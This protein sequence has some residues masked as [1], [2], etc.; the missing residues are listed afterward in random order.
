MRAPLTA[1]LAPAAATALLCALPTAHAGA[2]GIDE[3]I[4]VAVAGYPSIASVQSERQAAASRIAQAWAR[5]LPVLDVGATAR[6]RGL[7]P[8]GP[9]P[10]L[11]VNVYAGGSIEALVDRETL[12]ERSL[13][14]REAQVREEVAF[15]A[16]QAYLRLLRSLRV[17]DARR[18]SVQRHQRLVADFE[19]I[20]RMDP[21]RRYDLVQARSRL[22]V[23]EGQLQDAVAEV[24]SARNVLAK[25]Y[26]Y[27]WDE[28]AMAL[29]DP[30]RGA[31]D[32]EPDAT[33][34]AHP[35]V[36][37]ARHALASAQAN[38]RALRLERGPRLDFEAQGGREALSRFVL[39]WP[40]LDRT[41]GAAEQGA[42]AAL[43]GAEAAVRQA[44]LEVAEALAQARED[45]AAALRRLA[46]ANAQ[47]ALDR[48]LVD[49]Y[50][51]QFRIGRRNLLDLLA[52]FA[53]LGA[54]EARLAAGEV[55]VALAGVRHAFAAG[56]LADAYAATP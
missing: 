35:A 51:A 28:A 9:L 49:I 2:T 30:T 56:R 55:D 20:T 13:E 44:E 39:S 11:R 14:R 19:Q 33:L 50:F 45:Q 24:A 5:H 8:S 18:A 10:R 34:A 12:L 52:A 21:G 4:R 22:S 1:R 25:Y 17:A 47:A 27:R 42:A 6:V 36:S 43:I 31:T 46:Q 29:P 54:A 40:V 37:A 48:E 38:V 32:E 23:A 3:V 41:L 15:A 53:E 7:P 16:G 26:P